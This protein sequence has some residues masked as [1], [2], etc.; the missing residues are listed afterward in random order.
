MV[1]FCSVFVCSGGRTIQ[2]LELC[3][4]D[5][6]LLQRN[7]AA[8]MDFLHQ[9]KKALKPPLILLFLVPKSHLLSHFPALAALS[10]IFFLF[11]NSNVDFTGPP[12]KVLRRA[13]VLSSERAPSAWQQG[14]ETLRMC[15]QLEA[16][17]KSGK[18]KEGGGRVG[19]VADRCCWLLLRPP[20]GGAVSPYSHTQASPKPQLLNFSRQRSHIWKKWLG[21]V[22]GF[23][24]GLL[25]LSSQVFHTLSPSAGW[26]CPKTA[27]A[28]VVLTRLHLL[29][30]HSH[31]ACLTVGL[32]L[33]I[34]L[35]LC[36]RS[37]CTFCLEILVFWSTK[38]H[39]PPHPTPNP[40]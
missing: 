27:S 11:S 29:T 33:W 37:H 5:G 20:L 10:C 23:F 9:N 3:T 1:Y 4:K 17:K 35:P 26:I 22:L 15:L 19:D 21:F 2:W 40:I 25:P 34:T 14:L 39:F 12:S 28:H 38:S 32:R 7:K 31:L 8:C 36:G 18:K 16:A 13:W 30:S 6:N 24:Q